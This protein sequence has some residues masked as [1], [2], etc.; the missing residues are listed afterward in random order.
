MCE[1]ALSGIFQF[2]EFQNGQNDTIKF[3]IQNYNTLI[4]KQTGGGKNLCYAL[5]S[6]VIIGIMVVISPLKILVDDQVLELI[7]MG[8][9]CSYLYASTAQP[10]WY[11]RKVFQE[12][13]C[14]LIWVII[15]MPE[16]FKFNVGFWQM[17]EQ[18]RTS[19]GI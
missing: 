3:F 4:L 1:S 9:P 18:I 12:I 5:I 16:K 2:S 19:R 11:Q 14:K 7:K 13:A 10:I 15:I 6:V 8:I 17:L